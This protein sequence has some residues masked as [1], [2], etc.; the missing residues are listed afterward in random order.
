MS[1]VRRDRGYR[2]DRCRIRANVRRALENRL[3]ALERQSSALD[4][5]FC[6]SIVGGKPIAIDA[7]HGFAKVF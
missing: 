6:K 3:V 7:Y 5:S 1:R 2:R 4:T